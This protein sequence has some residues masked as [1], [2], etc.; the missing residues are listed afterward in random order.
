M[1]MHSQI[2]KAK[3]KLDPNILVAIKFNTHFR[4]LDGAPVEG[5]D[6]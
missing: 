6:E 2:P 5:L 4:L 3:L 1:L